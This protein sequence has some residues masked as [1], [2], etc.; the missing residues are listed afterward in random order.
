MDC[1]WFRGNCEITTYAFEELL[2]TKLR[3]L[4]QRKKGRDLFDL[5][6]ALDKGSVDEQKVMECYGRYMEFS[7]DKPPSYKQFMQNMELKMQDSE[8]L[9]DTELLLRPEADKFDPER[10]FRMVRDVF[11]ERLP[12]RRR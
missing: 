3:A 8:F 6:V 9:S 7:V 10:A 5:Q 11:I 12:G 2:G 4:Y 1:N